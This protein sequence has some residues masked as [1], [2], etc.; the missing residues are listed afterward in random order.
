MSTKKTKRPES[1]KRKAIE[2]DGAMASTWKNRSGSLSFQPGQLLYSESEE[3]LAQTV[4]R[5]RTDG[6][7]V[8]V[9]DPQEIPLDTHY[10]SLIESDVPVI[11][12]FSRLDSSRAENAIASATAFPLA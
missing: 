3:E 12:Q 2:P 11:V 4:R 1:G 7:K 6:Q 9:I 8:R 10:P 5:A